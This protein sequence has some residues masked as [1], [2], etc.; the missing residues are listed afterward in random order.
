MR[1]GPYGIAATPATPSLR[2]GLRERIGRDGPLA[3]PDFMAAALYDPELGYYARETRQV[4]RGGD[5]FTSVSVGPLFGELLAR[6]FLQEWKNSGAP[7]R[8]RIVEVG[9]HDGTLAADILGAISRL[10][11]PAYD[12]LEYVIPEPLPRLQAAQRE[13][14]VG[15]PLQARFVSDVSELFADPLPGVAFGN[16]LLDA[17]PFH[18]VEW[19]SNGWRECRVALDADGE[20]VW[21]ADHALP[22]SDPSLLAALTKLGADFPDGYRTEVRTNYRDFLEPL[23]RCLSS[24]LLLWFDYGFARPEF[25][26]P[27]RKAGT[28]R[29]FS[30]HRAAEN[31]LVT[32]GE[33]DITAHVDFTAVAETAISLG[34][35]PLTFR[36][37]GAW[38]TEIARDWLISLENQP[39]MAALRQFQTLTHPAHL[40]GSFHVL[41]LAWNQGGA[42][43]SA[44]DLHRLALRACS[45]PSSR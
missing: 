8:W 28:L 33:I 6:R 41:E 18:V 12:A 39:N 11:P 4:G 29:T 13:M 14:L 3:F 35:I 25:Y 9:A 20:F 40:G 27:D 15:F 32:P 7:A 30:K 23:T 24:G 5:F 26:H 1:V 34:C 42:E 44:T 10:A 36:N 19:K 22:I 38:L 43:I 2:A 17:L 21:A 16:E 31:P 37:Q 45:A